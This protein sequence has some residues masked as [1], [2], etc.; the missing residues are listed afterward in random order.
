MSRREQN[1]KSLIPMLV[2]VIILLLAISGILYR[3]FI[4]SPKTEQKKNYVTNL[5][6]VAGKVFLSRGS[7]SGDEFTTFS[8]VNWKK[9]EPNLSFSF[10]DKETAFIGKYQN[11]NLVYGWIMKSTPTKNGFF[12]FSQQQFVGT[13]QYVN[14]LNDD[15]KKKFEPLEN[16][17]LP[18]LK[19][20]QN[21]M[22]SKTVNIKKDIAKYRF[23]FENGNLIRENEPNAKLNY[24]MIYEQKNDI[25]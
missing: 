1:R 5:T 7:Y 3:V 15:Q 13:Q 10:K 25:K 22:F 24:Y 2:S 23:Y 16:S 21:L 20:Q 11:G 6:D 19:N 18:D 12:D 17:D 4:Y 8:T 9:A 14:A